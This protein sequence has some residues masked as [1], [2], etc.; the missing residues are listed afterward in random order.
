MKRYRPKSFLFLLLSGF[1]FVALPLLAALGSAAYFMGK[2]ADQSTQTVFRSAQ[3]TGESRRLLEQFL[4][5][6]RQARLYDLFTEPAEFS[7]IQKKHTEIQA[8]LLLLAS[9]PFAETDLQHINDLKEKETNLYDDITGDK[10]Q[11]RKAAL[12]RY[13]ET[14]SLARKIKEAS[15]N[16]I[17]LEAK[18]LQEQSFRYQKILLWQS[19]LLFI[20]SLL[21]I[22]LFVYL[23]IQPIRQIDQGIIQLGEGD[24]A[25]P[26]AVSGPRDLEFLGTKLN[27]LRERLADLEKE[28]NKFVA[29]VSHELKTPLSSIRE[30][31][32]LLIEEVVGPLTA[33]QKGVVKILSNNSRLLEKLIENIVNFN[34]AQARHLPLQ[35]ESFRLDTLISEVVDDHDPILLANRLKI[36]KDLPPITMNGDRHQIRA[37]IDNLLS[38][39]IKHSPPDSNISIA[40]ATTDEEIVIDITDSGPGIPEDEREQIFK[41]FF[42]GKS[43]QTGK[44]KGTGLGLA[45]ATEYMNNHQGTV[46]L[47]TDDTAGAHFRLTAPTKERSQ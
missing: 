8:T 4:A 44:M 2:M 24:F 47:V 20:I 42:Q 5:Q 40:M 18:K 30:G 6:E 25:T 43:A 37:V 12:S 21:L 28:K 15:H 35:M 19:I 17:W 10:P 16:L 9:F 27:W 31:T 39:A 33:Q 34:M 11:A 36:N 3:Y 46:K 23:L 14:N 32:G 29:H 7:G 1:T 13:Q 38:N 22:S 26:V 41:P 45:I